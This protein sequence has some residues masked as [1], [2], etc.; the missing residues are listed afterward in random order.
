MTGANGSS[1]DQ[2]DKANSHCGLI[3]VPLPT[4]FPLFKDHMLT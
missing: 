4:N 3:C 1:W 2:M